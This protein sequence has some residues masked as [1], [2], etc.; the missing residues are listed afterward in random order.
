M[1]M[2]RRDM[3][4]SAGGAAVG[5]AL[6]L[7]RAA[8]AQPA[9]PAGPVPPA[10]GA[11]PSPPGFARL[12][13][14]DIE[15]LVLSDGSYR[16]P[17]FQPLFVPEA[18]R[19]ELRSVM[20][21]GFAPPEFV[22]SEVNTLLLRIDGRLVLID[23]GFGEFENV[24]GGRL[25]KSL[26]EAGVAPASIDAVV[27]THAHRDHV[28]GLA[29]PDG[30]PAFPNARV[31][32]SR[33]EHEFWTTGEPDLAS[34]R[35]PEEWKTLW[36]QRTPT[37]LAAVQRRVELFA[38]GDKPLDDRIEFLDTAGHTVG[39]VS[40]LVHGGGESL[41]V[42]SDLVHN[43]VFSLA[44]PRWTTGFDW[45]TTRCVEA[46]L[47]TL[48]RVASERLRVLAYHLPWPGVGYI[49]RDGVERY[50]W[51]QDRWQW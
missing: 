21:A 37:V 26:A 8:A 20:T 51:H 29:R 31:Y 47:R 36:K 16:F 4:F 46:R 42:T 17:Q 2:D 3:L 13:I 5:L 49:A 44:R 27:I 24:P 19:D 14:G 43:H 41:L 12:T 40:P 18:P 7:T 32:M 48:D 10:P 34:M 6:G 50:R 1:R 28:W 33:R 23:T 11:F 15:G 39:H 45:D 25:M 38:P 35:V 9:A 22:P 30:S